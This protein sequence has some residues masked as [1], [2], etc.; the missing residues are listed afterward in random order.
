[1]TGAGGAAGAAT[2]TDGATGGG[3]SSATG[4]RGAVRVHDGRGYPLDP[5]VVHRSLR[6][7]RRRQYEVGRELR[8]PLVHRHLGAGPAGRLRVGRAAD[9]RLHEELDQPRPRALH[10]VEAGRSPTCRTRTSR[11]PPRRCGSSSRTIPT[12][13]ASISW[14][15]YAARRIRRCPSSTRAGFAV[16]RSTQTVFVNKE[17]DDARHGRGNARIRGPDLRGRA[18]FWSPAGPPQRR[19][20]RNQ[21][22]PGR[23][24]RQGPGPPIMAALLSPRPSSSRRCSRRYWSTAACS[25]CPHIGGGTDVLSSKARPTSLV[26]CVCHRPRDGRLHESRQRSYGAVF[27]GVIGGAWHS[28]VSDGV[29]RV[30]DRGGWIG[31]RSG[32]QRD[33]A[34]RGRC[35]WGSV[36]ERRWGERRDCRWRI[37]W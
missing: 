19:A 23:E 1:M 2:G 6:E 36:D 25:H 30:G 24:G 5:R 8:A 20:P 16:T 7:R 13:S 21:Q 15:S 4:L 31:E 27:H 18:R 32:G 14:R 28:R 37:G 33:H 26:A 3:G 10:R 34:G 11:R 17:V 35:E 29:G 22:H 12:S 9:V